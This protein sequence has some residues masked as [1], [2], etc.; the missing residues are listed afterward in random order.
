VYDPD[1]EDLAR[2]FLEDCHL[3]PAEMEKHAKGL[4]QAIQD[5]IET[6]IEMDVESNQGDGNG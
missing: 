6:Y 5:A 3:D 2:H 4:A 1:C